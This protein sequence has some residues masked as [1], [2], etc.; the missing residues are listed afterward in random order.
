MK[1]LWDNLLHTNPVLTINAVMAIVVL[2]AGFG[3]PLT[4]LQV[5]LIQGAVI[6]VLSWVLRRSVISPATAV[7][8]AKGGMPV[9][10]RED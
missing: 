1:N 7:G 9:V 6:A 4:I 5:S 2:A 3:L 10:G 8:L